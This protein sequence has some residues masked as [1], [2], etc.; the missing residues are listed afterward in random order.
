[1]TI[2]AKAKTKDLSFKAKADNCRPR[3]ASR[4]RPWPRGLHLWLGR[5]YKTE[6]SLVLCCVCRSDKPY[7]PLFFHHKPLMMMS[8]GLYALRVRE[9]RNLLVRK[10][11]IQASL[12][13][14]LHYSEKNYNKFK[15]YL[16]TCPSK[17]PLL[18][19]V[20]LTAAVPLVL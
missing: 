8:S 11:I 2:E 10:V 13:H 9:E 17:I 14:I 3:G 12:L 15:Q 19:L 18:A 4:S 5:R 1:M 20:K 16:K 7:V 6:S